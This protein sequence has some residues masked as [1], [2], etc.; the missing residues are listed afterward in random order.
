VDAVVLRSALEH[1]I[2][3][4]HGRVVTTDGEVVAVDGLRGWAEE[5]RA[6]W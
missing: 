1:A 4:F 6:K 2:G 5:H 3:T